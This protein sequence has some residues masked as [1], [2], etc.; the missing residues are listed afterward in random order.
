MKFKLLITLIAFLAITS[1]SVSPSYTVYVQNSTD[2][3]I[4]IAYK[5]INSNNGLVEK[6]ITLTSKERAMI[7]TTK[8]LQNESGR[9]RAEDCD[10]VAE[11]INAYNRDGAPSTIKWCSDDYHFDVVDIGQGEFT[12]DFKNEDF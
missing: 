2:D 7:I 10:Q 4:T 1:C 8:E 9:T 11:Y 3:D 12:I 5:S 6:S